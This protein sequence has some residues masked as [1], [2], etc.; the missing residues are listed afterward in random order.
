[1]VMSPARTRT[2]TPGGVQL[3]NQLG[4]AV[5]VHLEMEVGHDLD[6]HVR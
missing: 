5:G 3:A 1:M 6:L 2:T 4:A